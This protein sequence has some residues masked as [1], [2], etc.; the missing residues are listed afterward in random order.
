MEHLQSSLEQRDLVRRSNH[1]TVPSS[2]QVRKEWGS[3]GMVT[4]LVKG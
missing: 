3:P 1:L 4:T 2:P